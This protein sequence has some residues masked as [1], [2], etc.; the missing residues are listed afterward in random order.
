MDE[1]TLNKIEPLVDH[2]MKNYLWQFHSRAWD[3][4]RQNANI[5]GMTTKL[6][7][8]EEIDVSEPLERCYWV[9]AMI[10]AEDYRRLFPWLIESGENKIRELMSALLE[11]IEFLTVTGSLNKELTDQNY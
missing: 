8:K 5:L 1:T 6:L 10:L 11:R 3:R 7:L 9:D 4:T 2:I